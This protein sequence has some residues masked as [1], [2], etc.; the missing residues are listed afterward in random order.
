[1]TRGVPSIEPPATVRPRLVSIQDCGIYLGLS[2]HTIY[3]MVS[4]RRIPY[5][6]VGRLVKFDLTLLDAWLKKRTILP[7][8]P[9]HN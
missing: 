6:K 1:M 3:T 4:Q 7:I 2:V 9:K 5:L 8:S